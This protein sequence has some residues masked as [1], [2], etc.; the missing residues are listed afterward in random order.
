MSS[1]EDAPKHEEKEEQL[2]RILA[3]ATFAKHPVS[4]A[5][6]ER[7]VRDSLHGKPPEKGYE[8]E[9]ALGVEVFGKGARWDPSQESVVREGLRSLRGHLARYYSAEGAN[10]KVEISFPK[11]SGYAARFSY[12]AVDDGEETVRRLCEAFWHSFPDLTRCANVVQELKACVDKHPT[13]APAYG[14]LAEAILACAT[15]DQA[16]D[17]PISQAIVQAEEAVQTGLSLNRELWRLHVIAGALHC[18]RFKWAEADAAFKAALHLS[19]EEAGAHFWYIAFLI[20]VGRTE[21]AAQCISRR[22]ERP[23]TRLT[24]YLRPLFLYVMRDFDQAFHEMRI[25]PLA[26]RTNATWCCRAA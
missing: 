7:L 20:A 4:A 16:Y 1:E 26:Y 2:R 18:C 6:L 8:Y 11:R 14:V 25:L 5:L 21:E 23:H 22:L 24:P 3:S 12:R 10:D 17:V 9:H 13:Y 15:L 19:P